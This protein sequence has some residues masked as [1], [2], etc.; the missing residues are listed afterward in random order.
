MLPFHPL[1]TNGA[2][3]YDSTRWDTVQHRAEKQPY[4]IH[5]IKLL[6]Q[7]VAHPSHEIVNYKLIC[8]S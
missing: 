1:L 3:P 5:V 7:I 8:Y 2:S 6:Q 4:G